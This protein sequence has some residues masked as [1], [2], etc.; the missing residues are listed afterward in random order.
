VN[1]G[2]SAMRL[3][4][5][6]FISPRLMAAVKVGD[7][8]GT[9]HI[10]PVRRDGEDRVVWRYVIEDGDHTVLDEAADIRSGSGDPVDPRKAMAT[11]V[12]FIGAAADAYRVGMRGQASENAD[13]FPPDVME[14]AYMHDDELASLGLDL[15]EP[16]VGLD[17]EEPEIETAAQAPGRPFLQPAR[18][19]IVPAG[20]TTDVIEWNGQETEVVYNPRRYDV[21]V[22]HTSMT[23]DHE[24]D[25]TAAGWSYEGTD[26]HTVMWVRDRFAA[27]RAALDRSTSS[28][29]REV[30]TPPP[31]IGGLE[32]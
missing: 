5:P 11:L 6:L 19:G 23:E 14:W 15:E 26:G 3:T 9:L 1:P 2:D 29:G 12:G 22:V 13:L 30:G 27:A 16:E 4:P 24:G 10:S 28:L 8:A 18:S 31:D 17:L 32:L 20:W 7:G 25:L 21:M